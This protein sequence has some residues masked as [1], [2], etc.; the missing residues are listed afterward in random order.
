VPEL[1]ETRGVETKGGKSKAFS[2]L[3]FEVYNFVRLLGEFSSSLQLLE[4][5]L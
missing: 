2:A 5:F 3:S 4:D 1:A